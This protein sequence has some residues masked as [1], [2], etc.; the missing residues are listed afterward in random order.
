MYQAIIKKGKV[1]AESVPQPNVSEGCLLIKVVNSCISAGTEMSGVTNSGKPLIKR[2]LEQ[3]AQVAKVLNMAK[4]VGIQKTLAKVKGTLD[5]GNPTGYS[6]SGVVIGVGAG[7]SGFQ[8][9]DKVSAAGA[10]LANHAELVDVPQNLVMKMPDS[11]DFESASTVTLGG[12]AMQGVRRA[13][14]KL[15]E[16]CVVVGA[17]IL[18]L[19]T[20]QMLRAAGVRVAT[21]DLDDK[22]LD[23]AKQLGSEICI[24]GASED[25]VKAIQSW[26]GGYGTDCVIFTAATSSSGPLSQSFQMCRKKGKV[27]LVGVVGMEINRADIY[28]KELDF[29]ISTSYG[30]G[31]YDRSYEEKGVDYPYAYVR[32]TEKRNMEEYLRLLDSGLIN[33]SLLIN[34][35]YP[36]ESVTEAYE[37]L[38]QGDK[39]LMVLLEYGNFDDAKLQQYLEG[40][41]KVILKN[42][43]TKKSGAINVALIGAGGF[44]TGMHLPNMEKMSDKYQLYAVMSRK[45]HSAKSVAKQ[46]GAKYATTEL[47]DILND[48]DVDLVMIA[49]RHDSH[50]EFALK[51]LQA[52]KHVFVE[53]P[54]ATNLKELEKIKEFYN[55]NANFKPVLFTGFNRRF[56][57]YTQEILQHTNKR[58]NPLI[59]NYRMNAGHIPSDHWVHENGGRIVGEGC[60]IVDLMTAIVGEKVESFTSHELSPSNDMYLT[61]DNKCLS[62][63]YAD[64]S[65]AN[66]SYFSVGSKELSKEF[67]EI[68]FDGKS[69]IMDDYKTLKGYGVKV[70]KLSTNISEK[71]Q[72]EEL[73]HLYECLSGKN[74]NWPI[75]FWEQV[76]TT[77][78][79]FHA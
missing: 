10:G 49:T 77:E 63:K 29:K 40:D 32:W 17:G 16:F 41:K 74:P 65:I 57:P 70:K 2:A 62:I 14:L 35:K 20:I 79:T 59:I 50:A 54:L 43:V 19:L 3:P 66:I 12:I 55:S 30:P 23:I 15:G 69:I 21:I 13:D 34:G 7:V 52:G 46:F 9:G 48:K 33:L 68:H 51:S 36:I 31:R 61:S 76:Q 60:H 42:N 4:S 44:A 73:E 38:S 26:S 58:V 71:G 24:N 28:A 22:R 5:A 1:L 47:D 18:G 75:E 53:K 6:I 37:S 72:F 67:M 64:G 27:I 25:S 39:P 78:L 56:S 11:L 45:G 8:I